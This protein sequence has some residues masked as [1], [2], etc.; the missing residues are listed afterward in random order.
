MGT[1]RRSIGLVRTGNAG[2]RDTPPPLGSAAAAPPDDAAADDARRRR[3]GE[4]EA[5]VHEA[6]ERGVCWVGAG[7][8]GF[9]DELLSEAK[10]GASAGGAKVG[11]SEVGGGVGEEVESVG[12]GRDEVPKT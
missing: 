5:A 11:A 12:P 3:E 10:L 7:C 4:G 8:E 9:A 2:R 1:E 6:E